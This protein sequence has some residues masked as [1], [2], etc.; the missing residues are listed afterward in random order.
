MEQQWEGRGGAGFLEKVMLEG[1]LEIWV[2]LP[3]KLGVWG[4]TGKRV[5]KEWCVLKGGAE[6]DGW[7]VRSMEPAKAAELRATSRRA[8]GTN[9]SFPLG[10]D[11]GN[12]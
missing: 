2:R 12:V 11:T 9:D 4:R 5:E 6:S 1:H 3:R 10:T 8:L 7:G